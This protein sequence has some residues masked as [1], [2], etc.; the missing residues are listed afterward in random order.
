MRPHAALTLALLL[1]AAPVHS[2]LVPQPENGDPRLQVVDFDPGQVILLR[3]APGYQVT[4][5]LSPDEQVQSVAVGNG[6]AWNV[7]SDQ[8]R[9]RLFVKALSDSQ[10]TNMTVITTVRVYNFQLVPAEIDAPY[11]VRIRYAQAATPLVP[12][13]YVDVSSV[14]RRLSRYRIAGAKVLRPTSVS[15]DG[16]RTYIIFPPDIDLPAVYEIDGSGNEQLTS[17]TMRDDVFVIDRVVTA[18]TF[19]RD[20]LLARAERLREKVKGR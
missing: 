10:P 19:R 15:E 5:L 13:G 11:F 6:G 17:G 18:L 4:V 8:S 14:K 7:G 12:D 9:S 16:E 20:R 3:G 1:C 2:Q